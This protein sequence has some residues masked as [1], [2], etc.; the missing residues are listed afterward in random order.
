MRL[1]LFFLLNETQIER[2][3]KSSLRKSDFFPVIFP[4]L[5]T[6]FTLTIIPCCI[7]QTWT[8]IQLWVGIN[9][10]V[11]VVVY[12][13]CLYLAW[14]AAGIKGSHTESSGQWCVFLMKDTRAQIT[15][16]FKCCFTV[17]AATAEAAQCVGVH[18]TGL[19]FFY[20]H[21]FQD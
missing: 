17:N 4:A 16:M 15:V 10:K 8:R 1:D 14:L 6:A 3:W 11:I 9:W 19:C 13:Q 12:S 20:I 21:Y 7:G 18:D 5:C 2:L